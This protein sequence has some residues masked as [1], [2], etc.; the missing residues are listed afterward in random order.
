MA[1]SVAG[2]MRLPAR[3]PPSIITDSVMTN[4]LQALGTIAPSDRK[5]NRTSPTLRLRHKAKTYPSRPSCR[6]TAHQSGPASATAYLQ[7]AN[8]I[9]AN[10]AL[11]QIVTKAAA[12][13]DEI[14]IPGLAGYEA[15]TTPTSQR[16]AAARRTCLRSVLVAKQKKTRGMQHGTGLFNYIAQRASLLQ[17]RRHP[18]LPRWIHIVIALATIVLVWFGVQEALASAHARRVQHGEVPHLFMLLTFAYRW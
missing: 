9:N 1:A 4:N 6:T 11:Q 17:Q 13:R 3:E 18:P 15:T 12:R 14:R 16:P 7:D 10:L 8:Q 2:Q 5:T